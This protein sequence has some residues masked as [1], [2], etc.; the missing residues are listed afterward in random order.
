MV[1]CAHQIVIFNIAT[2]RLQ[3]THKFLLLTLDQMN[4]Q[5]QVVSFHCLNLWP[6]A[7]SH[8]NNKKVSYTSYLVYTINGWY[9]I[10]STSN[11]FLQFTTMLQTTC[12]IIS[13]PNTMIYSIGHHGLDCFDFSLFEPIGQL[14]INYGE[15]FPQP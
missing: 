5:F 14:V 4:N 1:N 11:R 12:L 8:C 13:S 10:I 6:L 7:T 2:W 9:E 15:V 3:F